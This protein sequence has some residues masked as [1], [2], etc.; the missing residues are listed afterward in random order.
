VQDNCTSYQ[1]FD[2]YQRFGTGE[3]NTSIYLCRDLKFDIQKI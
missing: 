3:A 1:T 2:H